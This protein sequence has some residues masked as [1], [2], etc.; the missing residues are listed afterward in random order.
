MCHGRIP[1][2]SFPSLFMMSMSWIRIDNFLN[3]QSD[4]PQI[5]IR[6]LQANICLACFGS[7][8]LFIIKEKFM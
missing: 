3:I 4:Y 6:W 8:F 7:Y 1:Q 2:K 5:S